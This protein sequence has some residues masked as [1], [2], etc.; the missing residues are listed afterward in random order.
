MTN[1]YIECLE[2]LETLMEAGKLEEVNRILIQELNMPYV[3]EPYLTKFNELKSRVH[4]SRGGSR[5]SLCF[6]EIIDLLQKDTTSQM[7]ALSSLESMNLH[8]YQGDIK[9]LLELNTL[10]DVVKKHILICCKEQNLDMTVKIQMN[11][12]EVSVDIAQLQDPFTNPKYLEIYQALS[13]TFEVNNPSMFAI[14]LEVLNGRVFE[15]YPFWDDSLDATSI[16]KQVNT[17]F[18]IDV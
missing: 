3:P 15:A 1:Y 7:V 12:S 16:E 4:E 17:F 18:G 5:K 9:E 8:R 10:D 11:G 2:T 13:E 6:D 14:S